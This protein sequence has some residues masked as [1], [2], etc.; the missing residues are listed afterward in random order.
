MKLFTTIRLYGII[1]MMTLMSAIASAQFVCYNGLTVT[2]NPVGEFTLFPSDLLA[3]GD[4]SGLDATLSQMLFTCDDIGSNEVILEIYDGSDLIFSCISTVIV[5][6]QINPS[7][8]CLTNNEVVLDASGE[9]FFSYQDVVLDAIDACDIAQYSI[10]PISVQC[11][12]PNPIAVTVTVIDNGGNSA[13]CTTEVSW[14][15]YPDPTPNLAC[16]DEVHV[17]LLNGEDYEVTADI[18]LEG[19]PYACPAYYDVVIS[20]NFVPRPEPIITLDDTN[21]ILS[22]EVTDL[23]TSSTCWGNIIVFGYP[24]CNDPFVVCDDMCRSTPVGDCASGHTEDDNVEWPCDIAIDVDCDVNSIDPTPAYLL[25]NG[26]A[27]LEDVYPQIINDD[28]FILGMNYADTVF[29]GENETLVQRTWTI[30]DWHTMETYSY[31]QLITITTDGVMICDTLPWNTPAGDCASGHTFDDDVEWPADITVSTVF[32]SPDDLDLNPEVMDENV[33]PQ[34]IDSC[35]FMLTT[36]AD[37]Y[38][39]INDTTVNV[40]RTWVVTDWSTGNTWEYDQEIKVEN[41]S[42][43]SVVCVTREDGEPIPGVTLAPGIVT[44]DSGCYSFDDPSGMVITPLKD[45]PLQ[46]GVNLLDKIMLMEGILAIR[47]L[48]YYQNRAADLSQNQ[49]IS[50]LDVVMLDKILDGTFV[51]SFDH[52]WMFFDQLT[53]QQS[54]DI[55]NPFLP[56]HFI[57]VKM[58]DLDNSAP[59]NGFGGFDPIGLQCDDEILNK[60]EQYEVSFKLSEDTR[61]QGFTLRL[62]NPLNTLNISGITAEGLPGFSM[63]THVVIEPGAIT[64]NYIAPEEYLNYGI[65]LPSGSA[66]FKLAFSPTINTFLSQEL[67]LSTNQDNILRS[68][69]DESGLEFA[70]DWE[71][72]IISSV[73]GLEDGQVIEFFPNP[74]TDEIQFKGLDQ[75]Q[76]GRISVF[77]PLGRMHYQGPLADQVNLSDLTPGLYYLNIRLDNGKMHTAP[78]TKM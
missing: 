18:L 30:I 70:L 51:P 22:Y 38:F 40:V 55:S 19:G 61:V 69:E 13:F 52:N 77:D 72:L 75:D 64:I 11:G 65:A 76:S 37:E 39:T 25:N 78:M 2:L 36:Y 59:L 7:V 3:D 17:S 53:H 50:T 15:D 14:S 49:V 47:T 24:D 60:K 35:Q 27:E 68:R 5:E 29:P 46:E 67:V 71:N 66:L 23:S 16:N 34:L 48:S 62:E 26:L 42:G 63:D 32:I 12:D 73:I 9:Y 43:S 74:V 54:M 41:V 56:Y 10:D 33:R 57:G 6:D 45:A 8:I 1:F 58:G 28:C 4:L 44:D 21:K 31:T 20:E